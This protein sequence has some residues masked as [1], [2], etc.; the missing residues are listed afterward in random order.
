MQLFQNWKK[1]KPKLTEEEG[2]EIL[3]TICQDILNKDYSQLELHLCPDTFPQVLFRACL[4]YH[5]P[6]I[7]TVN[8]FTRF[9]LTCSSTLG[10]GVALQ[11][12]HFH[13]IEPTII[14]VAIWSGDLTSIQILLRCGAIVTKQHI[15]FAIFCNNHLMLT[16]LITYNLRENQTLRIW[17]KGQRLLNKREL[18]KQSFP[19]CAQYYIQRQKYRSEALI[20]YILLAR[21]TSILACLDMDSLCLSNAKNVLVA[22]LLAGD[23]AILSRY[24]D[25]H[26]EFSKHLLSKLE[27]NGKSPIDLSIMLIEP[28][29][30]RLLLKHGAFFDN[31]C[32]V[33]ILKKLRKVDVPLSRCRKHIANLVSMFAILA[34]HNNTIKPNALK[35]G[36]SMAYSCTKSSDVGN[37]TTHLEAA[38]LY[39]VS[40]LEQTS[41]WSDYLFNAL[42]DLGTSLQPIYLS[43]CCDRGLFR[44]ADKL[45]VSGCLIEPSKVS[46]NENS[47]AANGWPKNEDGV[48]YCQQVVP[49]KLIC[50]RQ[51]NAFNSLTPQFKETLIFVEVNSGSSKDI[52][53]KGAAQV[54]PHEESP[55]GGIDLIE[56]PMQSPKRREEPKA[57]FVILDN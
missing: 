53:S 10:H 29:T 23:T 34:T 49:L 28:G 17:N 26:P 32:L 22:C 9:L 41:M 21:A 46:L 39:T 43:I 54:V 25:I 5:G 18:T 47:N 40:K 48:R 12:S 52:E 44:W 8:E 16:E 15:I 1:R 37:V 6:W 35:I 56:V 27:I 31:E 14:L 57:A 30:L 45:V 11:G 13:S 38:L 24:F 19:P 20:A 36:S 3:A 55:A 42:I 2:Q 4:Q 7:S 51:L 33:T 50:I